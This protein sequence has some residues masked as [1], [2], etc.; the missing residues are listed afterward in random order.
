MQIEY[1][2]PPATFNAADET[3]VPAEV[4][5]ADKPITPHQQHGSSPGPSLNSKEEFFLP[6]T[7]IRCPL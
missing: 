4:T 6:D 1:H 5:T 3:I 2:L 7:D